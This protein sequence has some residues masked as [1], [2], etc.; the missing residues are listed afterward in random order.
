ME[1]LSKMVER[2]SG[3]RWMQVLPFGRDI[4]TLLR[5]TF[6]IISKIL[7]FYYYY[8]YCYYLFYYHLTH[9]DVLYFLSTMPSSLFI[10]ILLAGMIITVCYS[11]SIFFSFTYFSPRGPVT[12]CGQN[13]R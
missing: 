11:L 10:P 1:H 6:Q 2:I 7:L 5:I 9:A 8:Y 4:V 13:G 3:R 12:R